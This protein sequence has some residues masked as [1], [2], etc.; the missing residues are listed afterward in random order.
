MALSDNAL[1]SLDDVKRYYFPDM[2]KSKSQDDDNIEALI[3]NITDQ[4][5]TYCGVDSFHDNDYTEYIDSK[6]SQYLFVTNTPLNSVAS[7][8]DD[9]DWTW[10]ENTLIDSDDYRIKN[11]RYLTFKF[12]FYEGNE[13][14]KITY[15]GGFAT[16]PGDLKLACIKEVS[17]AFKNRYDFDLISKSLEDGSINRVDDG[18]MPST[19]QILTK[20]K[21]IRV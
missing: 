19:K 1:V 8:Y 21:N 10:G 11:G 7:I 5:E 3:D 12:G 17:R 6:N 13:N 14:I 2:D 15:N 20:Y 18:L 9:S 16:I 4:F